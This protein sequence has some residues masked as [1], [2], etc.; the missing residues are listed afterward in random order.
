MKNLALVSAL[1]LAVA[2][3]ALAES[4]KP[5]MNKAETSTSFITSAG[6]TDTRTSHWIGAPVKNSSDET[7]GDINDFV[8][9]A[10]GDI[11]AVVA[12]VGGFLGLGEKN[13]GL[14][15]DRVKLVTN[16]DGDHVVMV[17]VTKDQ[18]MNAPDFKLGEKTMRDRAK[19]ASDAAAKTYEKAKENVK[20]GYEAAKESVE[21]N[22]EAAKETVKENYDAAKKAVSEEEADSGRNKPT[23]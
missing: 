10:D 12:G 6:A 7:V 20:A 11:V 23:Q 14:A 2:S 19:E 8:I 15:Y 22:Y 3:P 5:E 13:V 1:A 18:L 9:G 16:A 17:D 4:P 21:K